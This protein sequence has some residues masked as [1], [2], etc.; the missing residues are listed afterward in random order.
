M[1]KKVQK[2]LEELG[3]EM[4]SEEPVN[5]VKTE[6]INESKKKQRLIAM[7]PEINS[8][9]NDLGMSAI[10]LLNKPKRDF[11]AAASSIKNDG[12]KDIDFN[13]FLKN[14]QVY[15]PGLLNNLDDIEKK[16][17]NLRLAQRDGLQ[18]KDNSG[19]KFDRKSGKT[20]GNF[21]KIAQN[22]GGIDNAQKELQRMYNYDGKRWDPSWR[23]NTNNPEEMRKITGTSLYD[24]YD[25]DDIVRR[26][27]QLKKKKSGNAELDIAAQSPSQK[28][29]LGVNNAIDGIDYRDPSFYGN[30]I[31]DIKNVKKNAIEEIKDSRND[32]KPLP[33][34]DSYTA[35]ELQEAFL[36]AGLDTNK[37]TFEY[38]AEQLGFEVV[39]PNILE[40]LRRR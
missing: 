5:T 3:F 23:N 2:L 6:T 21:Y 14:N 39:R 11:F 1:N 18:Y 40:S 26:I 38:L 29:M 31:S 20:G 34:P 22:S 35:E 28:M 27:V 32:N 24:T 25:E 15:Y 8:R 13:S 4:L 36:L 12:D 17:Q 7:L 37:Y 10:N 30:I 33:I 9:I 19:W 16:I